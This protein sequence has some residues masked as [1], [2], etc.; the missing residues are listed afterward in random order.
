MSLKTKNYYADVAPLA[1]HGTRLMALFIDAIILGVIAGFLFPAMGEISLIAD[2]FITITYQWFFLTTWDGQTPGK[3]LLG[4]R[5]VKTDG[6]SLT[7][8]DAA[9]RAVGYFVNTAFF[10]LGWL[11]SLFDS[12]RRGWHD[13]F[14]GTIVIR[15]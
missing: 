10:M 12:N 5:V 8:V 14:A 15:D 7:G 6:A 11:W 4:I 13:L 9:I 1:G 3:R 2:L